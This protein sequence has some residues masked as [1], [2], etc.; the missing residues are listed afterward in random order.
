MHR[1]DI[2][3]SGLSCM[4]CARKVEHLLV[5]E[6]GALIHE[7]TPKLVCLETNSPFIEIESSILTLGYHAGHQYHFHLEGLS[8]NKR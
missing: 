4:G 8:C 7:L 2:P 3:L 6:H 5:K 1:L